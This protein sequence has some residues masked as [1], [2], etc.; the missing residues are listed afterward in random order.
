M[1]KTTLQLKNSLNRLHVRLAF[2]LIPLACFALSPQARAQ[3]CQEG[4]DTSTNN[5]FLGEDAL[6]SNNGGNYNNWIDTGNNTDPNRASHLDNG[7]INTNNPGDA[8]AQINQG[9]NELSQLRQDMANDPETASQIDAL[10]EEV[11]KLDPKRF[12]GNQAMVDE[13]HNR[14]LNDVDRLEMQL[15]SK[16]E[17]GD[18]SGQVRST[19]PMPVPAGYQD[20]VSEYFRKL[21]KNQ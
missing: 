17:T 13:L 9:L 19:D 21:S 16:G 2:L 11:K 18:Q 10:M 20:A 3:T 12:P 15:R 14:V 5:T 8:Q 4:C 6:F 7:N 1:K